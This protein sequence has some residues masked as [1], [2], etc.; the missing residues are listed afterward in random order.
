VPEPEV[1]L[2]GPVAGVPPYLQP[3]AH[4]LLQCREEIEAAVSTLTAEDLERSPG[5]VATVAFHI[6][7]SMGSLDRLFT[8]ARGESLS[9]AQ[10]A[11]LVSEK[12]R[13]DP[14]EA[15]TALLAQFRSAIDRAIAQL[16]II[17]ESTLLDARKVGRAQLPS[18]VLGLLFHAAE[19]TQRHTGQL[20]TTAKL[21]SSASRAP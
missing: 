10:R 1:W 18:N 20:V 15:P 3:V 8:Y 17:D 19:H 13:S 14:S 21:L 2:R 7:H 6:R 11:W 12:Q 4:C 16:G 5:N 9:Q